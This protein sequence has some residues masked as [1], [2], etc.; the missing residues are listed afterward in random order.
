MKNKLSVWRWILPLLFLFTSLS[1]LS[2]ACPPPEE[3]KQRLAGQFSMMINDSTRCEAYPYLSADGLRLYFTTDR[4]GGFGRLYFCSRNSV[5]ENFNAPKPLSKK[6]ADGYYAATLTNDELTLYC[7]KD[8]EIYISTRKSLN[9]EFSTPK[10]LKDFAAGWKFA[11]AISPDGNE[12]II[13]H[14]ADGDDEAVH[15]RKKTSGKFEKT[16]RLETPGGEEPD[17]GQF[18]KDGLFFY[19]SFEQKTTAG[20]TSV[21]FQQKIIRYKRNSLTESFIYDSEVNELNNDLRN[22]QPTMNEDG[23]IFIV[24]STTKNLWD[25]NDL[26]MINTENLWQTKVIDEPKEDVSIDSVFRFAFDTSIALWVCGGSF[27]EIEQIIIVEEE[28][29]ALPSATDKIDVP[30]RVRIYPNPFTDNL[31][32]T[33]PDKNRDA[34]FEL[35]DISGRKLMS[36]KLTSTYNRVQFN[37]TMTGLLVYRI[38]SASGQLISTGK[39]VKK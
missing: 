17:P 14:S 5:S 39:L 3:Q 32:I 27:V 16:Y 18:S 26:R 36:A 35:L 15:Y 6:I 2:Q 9:D 11:P 37:K 1:A 22:H 7:S 21:D 38:S 8:G 33:L 34:V 29:Q 4:E 30:I 24:A 20:T 31:T 25:E 13:I 10:Q 19:L 28:T 23:S 12:I